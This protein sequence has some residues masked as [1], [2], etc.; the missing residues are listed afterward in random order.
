[1]GNHLQQTLAVWADEKERLS[2]RMRSGEVERDQLEH[3]LMK[4]IAR[5]HSSM[6]NA[7]ADQA[8]T[9][10]E[11][12]CPALMEMN[13]SLREAYAFL[14]EQQQQLEEATMERDRLQAHLITA[15]ERVSRQHAGLVPD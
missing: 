7:S 13:A 9:V 2:R 1:M 6:S 3:N 10:K 12:E 14:C 8:A 11:R 15:L 4:E 5:L